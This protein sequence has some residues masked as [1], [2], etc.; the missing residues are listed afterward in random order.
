MAY[1]LTA[2]AGRGRLKTSPGKP[3][4]PGRKQVFRREEAGEAVGDVIARAGEAGPG[5]PLLERVMAGGR[6]LAEDS[7]DLERARERA[8][9]E[10]GRLPVRVRGLAPAD[11]A[12]PVAVS[13]AL[14]RYAAEVRREIE[15]G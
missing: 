1:K 6:T 13:A 9:R 5:R 4:L 10:I 11:P 3:I 7:G 15:A 8:R 12:Y 14:A 2:Y